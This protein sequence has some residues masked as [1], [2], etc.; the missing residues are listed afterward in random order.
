[1]SSFEINSKLNRP[2]ENCTQKEF[3]TIETIKEL[4]NT[5]MLFLKS[6]YYMLVISKIKPKNHFLFFRIQLL[7][8]GDVHPNPGPQVPQFAKTWAP[9]KKSGL[10]FIHININ[11]LLTKIDE[12]R[13]IALNTNAAVIGITESKLDESVMNSEI[14][15][16]NYILI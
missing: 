12:I 4:N 8:S 14:N 15:I 6:N 9:F 5:S 2:L 13:S 10:H 16:D 7:L 11:S 3:F 1:M